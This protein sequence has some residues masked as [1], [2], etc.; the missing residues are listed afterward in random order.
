MIFDIFT[1][2]SNAN[3]FGNLFLTWQLNNYIVW[4]RTSRQRSEILPNTMYYFLVL[5]LSYGIIKYIL[6]IPSRHG[7]NFS[8]AFDI[9]T[10]TADAKSEHANDRTVS[11]TCPKVGCL[12]SFKL[13]SSPITQCSLENNSRFLTPAWDPFPLTVTNHERIGCQ[14]ENK[15]QTGW[16]VLVLLLGFGS[17]HNE[18]DSW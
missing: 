16:L 13:W 2:L 4:L 6:L 7:T 15:R 14:K 12:A 1:L 9:P 5:H 3:V 18:P 17:G 11:V 10:K 8:V